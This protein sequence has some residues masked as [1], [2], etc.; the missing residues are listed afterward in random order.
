MNYLEVLSNL[1]DPMKTFTLL[2]L[3][4]LPFTSPLLGSN[5]DQRISNLERDVSQL[6]QQVRDLSSSSSVSSHSGSSQGGYRVK[7]GDTLWGIAKSNGVSVS[8][9]QSANPGLNPSRLKIGTSL[10][11]PGKKKSTTSSST[12][13]GPTTGHAIHSGETLGGIANR[14][15]ISL[16]QLMS[17]NPGLNPR[18]LQIGQNVQIPSERKSVSSY[19]APSRPPE[20]ESSPSPKSAPAPVREQV[21]QAGA[22]HRSSGP[23]LVTVGQNRRLDD[24]ARF[25]STD[26][27]TINTLNQVSLSPAQVIKMGSQIYVPQQ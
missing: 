15:G 12:F 22:P 27:A 13:S 3:L 4:A 2:S 23:E 9:L 11:I 8:R 5:Q 25:Y 17:A 20:E 26:V 21:R 1:R 18:R 6:R 16:S 14:H 24:I 19:Q 7:G 10:N